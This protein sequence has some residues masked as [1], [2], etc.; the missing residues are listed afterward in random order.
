MNVLDAVGTKGAY[1][2]IFVNLGSGKQY[3]CIKKAWT[4]LRKEADLSNIRIHDL[5]HQ[6]ASMLVNEGRSLY[7]VQQLLG[8]SDPKVTERYAHLAASTLQQAANSVAPRLG[9]PS[10]L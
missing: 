3:T 4:R 9:R 8:H 5:R 7:E 10:G 1:E 2:H 6:Y